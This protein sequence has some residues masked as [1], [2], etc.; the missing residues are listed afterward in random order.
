MGQHK[1]DHFPGLPQDYRSPYG[2]VAP[3]NRLG[4]K[5]GL[6][7]RPWPFAVGRMGLVQS[8]SEAVSSLKP[9]IF[10]LA[11]VGC[12]IDLQLEGAEATLGLKCSE[13]HSF[14]LFNLSSAI[15][16]LSSLRPII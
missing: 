1:L 16:Y 13:N 2:Q 4:S 9:N 12:G 14:N 11:T 5:E 15:Y 3:I 7:S 6:Q 8:H 10:S